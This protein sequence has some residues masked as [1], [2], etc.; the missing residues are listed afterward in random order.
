M[1]HAIVNGLLLAVFLVSAS[2]AAEESTFSTVFSHYETIR[3]VLIEDSTEGVPKHA[4]AIAEAV[5]SLRTD[6]S[7]ADA[8]ASPEDA[9]A[10]KKLL[11][12]IEERSLRVAGAED[13]AA[14]R[15]ELAELTKPLV[16]W[17]EFVEG[18]RPVV[19]YCPMERKA[20]LQPDE[21][22][23]NPYAPYMLRCGEIVQR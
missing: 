2:S 7:A 6:F 11:P 23:G 10:V 20:W 1:R 19:A 18:P 12:E 15:D 8:G 4:A 14:V 3:L 22:I 9:E 17:H 5:S 21:P 16:R 13:L